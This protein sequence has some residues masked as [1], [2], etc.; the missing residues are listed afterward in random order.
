MP[1]MRLDI[2]HATKEQKEA[3]VKELTPIFAK[4]INMP[5]ETIY[6]FINEYETDNVGV[7]HKLLS[8]IHKGKQI[9]QQISQ[10]EQTDEKSNHY[11]WKS[12][13]EF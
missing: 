13:K 7:G 8:E 3:L 5:E 9:E 11:Q 12:K 2:A 6:T 10:M 4:I 1:V